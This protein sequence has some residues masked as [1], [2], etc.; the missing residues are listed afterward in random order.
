MSMVFHS[1]A[2]RT[3]RII[4]SYYFPVFL[5]PLVFVI[6]VLYLY[7]FSYTYVFYTK[8]TKT[9]TTTMN[10]KM[11]KTETIHH[12]ANRQSIYSPSCPILFPFHAG[13]D[14][15]GLFPPIK[16]II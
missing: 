8:T 4:I 13:D 2:P 5:S 7:T 15:D 3:V 6:L 9:K 10:K 16:N 12:H 14:G 1:I 11:K